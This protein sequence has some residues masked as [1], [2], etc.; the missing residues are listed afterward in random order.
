MSRSTKM[1]IA[2]VAVAV[3]AFAIVGVV[4]S[5]EDDNDTATPTKNAETSEQLVRDDSVRLSDG[6]AD[7]PVLVEFLDPECEACRAIK[8]T[9]DQLKS[10]YGD[11]LTIVVRYMPL[12]K[13]SVNAAR[14]MEAAA[15]QG[16]FV[17]MYDLIYETQPQWGEQQTPEEEMFFAMAEQLKLDKDKFRAAYDDPATTAKVQRD[18]ADG[19]ALG[20]S[21]TP[22][23]FLNAE[24][25]E[26][27]KIDDLVGPVREAV[28]S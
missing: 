13:S 18:Q 17:D 21:G 25:L 10:D 15:A 26:L 2:L 22:T 4:A 1:S 27:T 14:A 20:V 28:G 8:P 9:V 5:G 7:A 16:R 3:V 6:G 11:D 12:H 19:E 23:F 24:K